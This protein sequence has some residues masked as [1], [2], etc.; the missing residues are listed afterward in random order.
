VKVT[1]ASSDEREIEGIK[2][3]PMVRADRFRVAWQSA[4]EAGMILIFV[5]ADSS[6]LFLVNNLTC[7]RLGTFPTLWIYAGGRRERSNK[8]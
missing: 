3:W 5:D 6:S 2:P 7:G 4:R 8:R 1:V